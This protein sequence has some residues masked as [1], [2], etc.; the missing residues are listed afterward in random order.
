MA[1]DIATTILAL[2]KDMEHRDRKHSEVVV[3]ITHGFMNDYECTQWFKLSGN[4]DSVNMK[5]G[6]WTTNLSFHP[7]RITD[8]S[9]DIIL[10]NVMKRFLEITIEQ[11]N[12]GSFNKDADYIRIEVI[13]GSMRLCSGCY[14]FPE[15]VFEW[16]IDSVADWMMGS[17][18]DDTDTTFFILRTAFRRYVRHALFL[19]ETSVD[20]CGRS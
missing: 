11:E 7:S 15:T 16:Q 5:F 8:H 13:K 4:K 14:Y 2:A 19:I 10:Q 20:D 6:D 3:A 9:L 12:V 1:H 17:S 18:R